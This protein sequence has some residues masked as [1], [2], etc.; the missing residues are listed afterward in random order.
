MADAYGGITLSTSNDC[1]VDAELLVELLNNFNWTNGYG[2]WITNQMDGKDTFWH[3]DDFNTQYPSLFPTEYT[4]IILKNDDGTLIRIPYEEATDENLRDY[5]DIEEE[6]VS[7]EALS[8][9]FSKALSNGWFEVACTAN[10]KN[11][12][13]YFQSLR[14]YADGKAIRK[15]IES[16]CCLTEAIDSIDVYEPIDIKFDELNT[17]AVAV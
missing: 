14:I 15:Q 3:C 16:G 17:E 1:V 11:R 12:Y 6:Y 10:E 13:V 2:D 7:L 9:H 4:A 5:W 8:K